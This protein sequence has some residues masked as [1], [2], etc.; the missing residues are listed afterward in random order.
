MNKFYAFLIKDFRL[1]KS[2]KINF[3]MIFIS[4][5]ITLLLFY[6]IFMTISLENENSFNEELFSNIFYGIVLIDLCFIV[7]SSLPRSINE[8]RH[9]GILEEI[10]YKN[11]WHIILSTFVWILIVFI[12]KS[13]IYFS[14]SSILID[15]PTTQNISFLKIT[16]ILIAT[17]IS[18]MGLSIIS[19]SYSIINLRSNALEKIIMTAST[20][21]GGAF[22]SVNLLPSIFIQVAQVL[23]ITH[24][25]NLVRNIND[26]LLNSINFIALIFLSFLFNIIGYF[27]IKKSID[28]AKKNGLLIYF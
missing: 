1:A 26:P 15:T 22:F 18:L 2:Y 16:T 10:L 12:F 28:K 20:F 13:F 27:L 9:Q 24:A 3:L 8:Y 19:A 17:F 25:L 4:P 6:M 21:L 14:I 23:P 11:E 5:F 7:I